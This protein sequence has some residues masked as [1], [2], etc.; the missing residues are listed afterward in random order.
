[1]AAKKRY[2]RSRKTTPYQE[3]VFI[4]ILVAAAATFS[5]RQ[6]MEDSNLG[7]IAAIFI[8]I[9]LFIGGCFYV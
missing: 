7:L 4:S 5:L 3:I 9:A 8:L 6:V 2:R 1:M